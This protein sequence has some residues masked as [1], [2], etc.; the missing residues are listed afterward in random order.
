MP[1]GY[2][3]FNVQELSGLLYVTY[4]KQDAA[5][6][7]DVNGQGH[8]FVDVFTPDGTLVRRLVRRGQLDSPW[9]LAIAPAGFGRF[10][11][12]LLV[13]NFGDGRIHAYDPHTGHFL[14]ALRDEHHRPVATDGLWGLRFGNGVTGD[15]TT[16]LFTV[17]PDDEAHGLFG[18][19]TAEH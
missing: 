13:G 12:A 7:D 8:G 11:G 15:A 9:G 4:A 19:L 3:P 1:H 5:A 18:T 10:S 6:H 17:G 14:G 2:A 16:L